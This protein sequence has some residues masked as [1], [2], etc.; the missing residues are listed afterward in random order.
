[1][2]ALGMEGEGER[3]RMGEV[4]GKMERRAVN[5]E[6]KNGRN[7]GMGRRLARDKEK[8]RNEN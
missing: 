5:D 7:G 1:M 2:G 3:S 4:Q 6:E 8:E